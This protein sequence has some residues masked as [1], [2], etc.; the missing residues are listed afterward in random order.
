MGKR[1]IGVILILLFIVL[2]YKYANALE[3]H[4]ILSPLIQHPVWLITGLFLYG[5]S[6]FLK[7]IAWTRLV[8]PHLSFKTSLY[9]ILY[10]L[11][12]NHLLPMKG[13]EV[14]RGYVAWQRDH[15]SFPLVISSVV[16]ARLLDII[17]LGILLLLGIGLHAIHFKKSWFIG[18]AVLLAI[19]IIVLL[20]YKRWPNKIKS[21]FSDVIHMI[22]S[23]SM[24]GTFLLIFVSWVLEAFLLWSVLKSYPFEINFLE[25]VW[26]N[27]ITILG[28]VFQITPGGI[29]T[30]E[31]VMTYSLQMVGVHASDG[32]EISLITHSLKFIFSY[33]I[34]LVVWLRYP[35]PLSYKTLSQ[36]VKGVKQP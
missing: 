28:Q 12:F 7:A 11:F 23:R 17:S 33:A 1:I 36:E 35:I 13:G 19:L 26:V 25:T 2:S 3:L 16:V 30:Y 15:L 14:V 20:N 27:S 24:L 29:A 4:S 21:L 18:V 31:T 10:S 32:F 9:G 34:G 8:S 5:S 6:F 22:W